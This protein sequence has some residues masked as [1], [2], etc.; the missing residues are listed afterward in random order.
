MRIEA[1]TELADQPGVRFLVLSQLFQ[2]SF[3]AR[4]RNGP[5]VFDQIGLAH[6]DTGVGET[7]RM[8]LV[9]GIDGDPKGTSG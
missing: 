7:D 2:K 6:P 8:L 5:E 3:G 9:I 1:D 4:M